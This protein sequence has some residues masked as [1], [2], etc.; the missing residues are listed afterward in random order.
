MQLWQLDWFLGLIGQERLPANSDSGLTIG[1]KG[2]RTVPRVAGSLNQIGCQAVH[3][4]AL[5]GWERSASR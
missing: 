4:C 2:Q 5:M 3:C 1:G